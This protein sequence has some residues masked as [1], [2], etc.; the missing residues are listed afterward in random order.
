MLDLVC[1]PAGDG[2]DVDAFVAGGTDR[3]YLISEG[4]DGISTAPL[5]TA[6]T[7]AVVTTA[8]RHSQTQPRGASTRH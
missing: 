5:V 8:R 3:L 2:L 4:G 1:P 7:A 6:F